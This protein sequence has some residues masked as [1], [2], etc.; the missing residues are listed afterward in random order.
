[1]R[2]FDSASFL[3]RIPTFLSRNRVGRSEIDDG[4]CSDFGGEMGRGGQGAEEEREK[5]MG[6]LCLSWLPGDIDGAALTSWA[7]GRLR[8]LLPFF[9]SEQH[10]S[11][12]TSY[13]I[14]GWWFMLL[15]LFVCSCQG[16]L[17][18][19][20]NHLKTVAYLAKM[21]WKCSHQQFTYSFSCIFNWKKNPIWW[22]TYVLHIE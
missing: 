16:H 20:F 3:E 5:W 7:R 15:Y 21:H 9:P 17:A 10:C 6:S 1:M 22:N 4:K 14:G 8:L 11:L 13:F 12:F 19:I 2:C 18:V